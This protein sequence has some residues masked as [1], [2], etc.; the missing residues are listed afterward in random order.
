MFDEEMAIVTA[1]AYAKGGN[2]E[3]YQ[4]VSNF[5]DMWRGNITS[6]DIKVEESLIGFRKLHELLSVQKEDYEKNGKV[7][8]VHYTGEFIKHLDVIIGKLQE[9]LTQTE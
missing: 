9:R 1:E 3:R 7:F 8:A 4:F 5:N 2:S 6:Q